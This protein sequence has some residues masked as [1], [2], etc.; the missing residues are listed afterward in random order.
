M[1]VADRKKLKRKKEMIEAS[2]RKKAKES[3]GADQ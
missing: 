1:P 2:K 3:Q